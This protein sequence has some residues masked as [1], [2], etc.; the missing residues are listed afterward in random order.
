MKKIQRKQCNRKIQKKKRFITFQNKNYNKLIKKKFIFALQLEKLK[1]NPNLKI[2]VKL[3]QMHSSQ[4]QQ[5][6]QYSIESPLSTSVLRRQIL[7]IFPNYLD[8]VCKD[9]RIIQCKK[10]IEELKAL[11]EDH[12]SNIEAVNFVKQKLKIAIFQ[13][14]YPECFTLFEAFYN[15]R[16]ADDLKEQQVS[17]FYSLS[18]IPSIQNLGY[19]LFNNER[20]CDKEGHGQELPEEQKEDLSNLITWPVIQNN[21]SNEQLR[22]VLAEIYNNNS[23]R[24][25]HLERLLCWFPDYLYHYHQLTQELFYGPGPIPID[26]RY[27]I[28]ILAS[29][30]F[31]CEYLH[32]RLSQQFLNIGGNLKWLEVGL[33]QVDVPKLQ[34]LAAFNSKLAYAPSEVC[35]NSKMIEELMQKGWQKNELMQAI[36]IITFYH[37]LA[38]ACQAFG[39]KSELD[40]RNSHFSLLS[41]TQTPIGSNLQSPKN[42]NSEDKLSAKKP[43]FDFANS[44]IENLLK[45]MTSSDQDQVGSNE[46]E[47]VQEK[48]LENKKKTSSHTLKEKDEVSSPVIKEQQKDQENETKFL[49]LRLFEKFQK[50]IMNPELRDKDERISQTLRYSDFNYNTHGFQITNQYALDLAQNSK[51]ILDI[52]KNMT[53]KNFNSSQ[54]L[55]TTPFRKAIK[56]YIQNIFGYTHFDADYKTEMNALLPIPLKTVLKLTVKRPFEI[57]YSHIQNINLKLMSSEVAHII[58]LATHARFEIELL[59]FLYPFQSF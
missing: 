35:K 25:P 5:E 1:K 47:Q 42:R 49:Q 11:L 58:L 30:N 18:E 40:L 37:A 53:N 3:S 56:L 22:Q 33:E 20:E 12:G 39:L 50:F 44:E 15:E 27:F 13:T 31:G 48:P 28:A 52:I 51:D 2:K 19:A 57:K 54:N 9:E 16:Y 17:E 43:N 24:I 7:E 4:N 26:Q 46:E 36:F 23:G 8:P 29:S 14:P 32:S 59:Y 38:C 55:S 21:V 34:A 41:K 45:R 10:S 6:Q